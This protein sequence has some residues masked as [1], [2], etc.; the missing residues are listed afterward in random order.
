LEVCRESLEKIIDSE[1]PYPALK[2]FAQEHGVSLQR[3]TRRL[4]IHV[5]LLL[6]KRAW[7]IRS[8]REAL[9]GKLA[10]AKAFAARYKHHLNRRK[11]SEDLAKRFEIPIHVARRIV[12]ET[13]AR[14]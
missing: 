9:L 5:S 2:K 14:N 10:H 8:R 12:V 4:P 7:E 1:G 13:G 3:I 6:K 11:R